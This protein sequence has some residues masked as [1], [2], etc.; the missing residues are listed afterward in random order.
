[1][2]P[3]LR[4][5][6]PLKKSARLQRAWRRCGRESAGACL[7]L[8][9]AVCALPEPGRDADDRLFTSL[10]QALQRLDLNLVPAE[11]RL[12]LPDPAGSGPQLCRQTGCLLWPEAAPE[13]A[14]GQLLRV[15]RVTLAGAAQSVPGGFAEVVVAAASGQG[16]PG[17]LLDAPT[18]GLLS[19]LLAGKDDLLRFVERVDARSDT[20]LTQALQECRERM[21]SASRVWRLELREVLLDALRGQARLPAGLGPVVEA[22][23]LELLPSNDHWPVP[24][25]REE[26]AAV[27]EPGLGSLRL[28]HSEL[29]RGT[30]LELQQ[31]GVRQ[32]GGGQLLLAAR[33]RLSL[34]SR[35]SAVESM[36][37]QRSGD[38]PELSGLLARLRELRQLPLELR[39]GLEGRT[40]AARVYSDLEAAGA[41]PERLRLL[42]SELALLGMRPYPAP[43]ETFPLPE[44]PDPGARLSADPQIPRGRL[45]RV[46]RQAF[47]WK[48]CLLGEPQYVLSSG[49]EDGLQRALRILS[50]RSQSET[51]AGLE[52][53][54]QQL[55][56]FLLK[57]R[58]A[59]LPQELVR[60]LLALTEIL[61]Q[62]HAELAAAIVDQLRMRGLEL[63]P[64]SPQL[65]GAEGSSADAEGCEVHA[66]EFAEQPAGSVL[67][68]LRTGYRYRGSLLRPAQV[69]LSRGPCPPLLAGWR[70]LLAAAP[71]AAAA[72]LREL[73]PASEDCDDARLLPCLLEIFDQLEASGPRELLEKLLAETGVE[74]IPAAHEATFSLARAGE[75]GVEVR[76]EPALEPEG[77]LLAV[78][79]RGYRWGARRRSARIRV[80]LGQS[81]PLVPLAFH[82]L[83][84]QPLELFD[85]QGAPLQ[86][87][88]PLSDACRQLART[89]L[90]R[91]SPRVPESGALFLHGLSLQLGSESETTWT[92]QI[93]FQLAH[94]G[95]RLVPGRADEPLPA[96]SWEG[97]ARRYHGEVCEGCC[98]GPYKPGL[99]W[100][101]RW[102]QAPEGTVS[103]GPPSTVLRRL[104][105]LRGALEGLAEPQLRSRLLRA[106]G[107]SLAELE[108]L[109]RAAH[110][111]WP[112]ARALVRVLDACDA[113][114]EPAAAPRHPELARQLCGDLQQL[115]VRVD[116]VVSGASFVAQSDGFTRTAKPVF[117]SQQGTVLAVAS[118][119]IFFRDAAF[120]AISELWVGAG[121]RPHV[122]AL[123]ERFA[124]E[125]RMA[126]IEDEA[127]EGLLAQ[128]RH[129]E[130]SALHFRI[131]EAVN[132]LYSWSVAGRPF[133]RGAH[134]MSEFLHG[135]LAPL[136]FSLV[137]IE[138]GAELASFGNHWCEPR[139]VH[140]AGAAGH[141]IVRVL[142][143]AFRDEAGEVV[144]RALVEVAR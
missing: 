138:P 5:L 135:V 112:G 130:A 118:R 36:L 33:L 134:F 106:L 38:W 121:Q 87:Q 74:F 96:S 65:A 119:A 131:I 50:E 20:N 97:L 6:G 15:R 22:L 57:T 90:Q 84:G 91:P 69:V 73:Q 10:G 32:R 12:E 128:T 86:L 53:L 9:H 2:K 141:S 108:C 61:P 47:L 17:Y 62:E 83:S 113:V 19:K 122:L 132:L 137:G 24:E 78:E 93:A 31:L 126:G 71:A 133:A 100:Q 89:W 30:I 39:D 27:F 144:Q 18:P 125:A 29:A 88:A 127:L 129:P 103:L 3:E 52:A 117:D 64:G 75:E 66:Q 99:L 34:G 142:R 95:A 37:V 45:L 116:T 1:M 120:R 51:L 102:L 123:L 101:G 48:G 80:S 114:G 26:P 43:D 25:Q 41:P 115:G 110:G 94:L 46:E 68:V 16:P 67:S 81:D 44:L 59:P 105:D 11:R 104:W 79:Q 40:L 139:F 54:Q 111:E 85:A 98:I 72:R 56:S 49:P 82:L 14:P 21:V 77:A 70:R 35:P 140:K 92:G 42:R 28:E 58:A 23:E 4:A 60:G 124:L 7:E 63:L 143:P 55:D 136:G 76:G 8:F 13:Q 107:E 109:P